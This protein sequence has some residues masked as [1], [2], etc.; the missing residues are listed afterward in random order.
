MQ[1]RVRFEAGSP[2]SG[3]RR[4]IISASFCPES[5][6]FSCPNG[7]SCFP[8]VFES[9]LLHKKL[10][11][12]LYVLSWM[13]WRG[14]Y[15]RL[16]SQCC[17]AP[18]RRFVLRGRLVLLCLLVYPVVQTSAVSACYRQRLKFW[19]A[20]WMEDLTSRSQRR[21]TA[22]WELMTSVSSRVSP[23]SN[24]ATRSHPPRP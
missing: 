5:R 7:R 3:G 8:N 6:F 11:Y 14:I 17:S 10:W 2:S 23:T 18:N 12:L 24:G 16:L 15:C 19:A 9:L 4:R 21:R 1:S 13:A 22:P 20:G